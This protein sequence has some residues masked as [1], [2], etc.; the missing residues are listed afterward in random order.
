MK[1]VSI[2]VRVSQE[3]S[4]F[5]EKYFEKKGT[6]VSNLIAWFHN[7]MTPIINNP[8]AEDSQEFGTRMY[9]V[10]SQLR[11]LE[12]LNQVALNNLKGKFEKNELCAILDVKNDG[13]MGLTHDPAHTLTDI[14][15]I[16]MEI[17][18][19]ETYENLGDKWEIDVKSL[20]N[21]LAELS[22]TETYALNLW[23]TDA[24]E[25]DNVFEMAEELSKSK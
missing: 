23:I 10:P 8:A 14:R 12:R 19:A 15:Y 3:V 11:V 4:D 25:K 17:E 22:A 21:K 2:S 1:D 5:L 6:G 7:H 18:D 24:W 9:K 13:G 20:C 16:I